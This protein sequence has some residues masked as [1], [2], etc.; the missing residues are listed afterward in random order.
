MSIGNSPKG[1]RKRR[2]KKRRVEERVRAKKT[3]KGFPATPVIR[4]EH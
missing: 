2:A 1:K 3:K 4:T